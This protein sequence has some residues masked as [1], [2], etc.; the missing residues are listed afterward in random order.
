MATQISR[1]LVALCALFFISSPTWSATLNFIGT[2]T[3]WFDGSNWQDATTGSTGTPPG[4]LDDVVVDSLNVII[5]PSQGSSAVSVASVDLMGTASLQTLPGTVLSI[6]GA[7]HVREESSV[8]YQSSEIQ[9]DQLA[10]PAS[11]ACPTC[12]VTNIFNP[13]TKDQRDIIVETIESGWTFGLGG[14]TPASPGNV[15]AGHYATLTAQTIQMAG[16]LDVQLFHGFVPTVG[17]QFRIIDAS[18]T[19]TGEFEGLANGAIAATPG[20][21]PLVIS[22]DANGVT[23]VAVPEP[24]TASLLLLTVACLVANRRP[25]HGRSGSRPVS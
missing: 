13:T 21:V 20:G 5:D 19:Y 4:A 9:L 15:G 17:D 8:T 18:S 10:V 16:T 11:L 7:M 14:T 24:G 23:L 12:F 2:D 3:N 25:R 1:N 22:Y 6:S